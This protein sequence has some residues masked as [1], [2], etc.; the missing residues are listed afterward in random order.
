MQL[1]CTFLEYVSLVATGPL[2]GEGVVRKRG[3]EL[4]GQL[5][6]LGRGTEVMTRH[7]HLEDGLIELS[8]VLLQDGKVFGQVI[9]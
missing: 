8:V 5:V 2:H 3:Q 4:L 1:I 6:P 9:S 7:A